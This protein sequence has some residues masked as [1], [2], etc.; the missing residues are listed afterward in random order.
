MSKTRTCSTEANKLLSFLTSEQ[1]KTLPIH[2]LSFMYSTGYSIMPF[3]VP[4]PALN[5]I[6]CIS[7]RSKRTNYENQTQRFSVNKIW[8]GP[9]KGTALAINLKALP[10][11]AKTLSHT[12][13]LFY[14]SALPAGTKEARIH[15]PKSPE[16][17]PYTLKVGATYSSGR[18][19]GSTKNISKAI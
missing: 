11:L 10:S 19:G 15:R 17:R 12:L 3:H 7:P 6:S 8:A 18:G 14:N 4:D 5:R 9:V 1:M 16:D 13:P 2:R